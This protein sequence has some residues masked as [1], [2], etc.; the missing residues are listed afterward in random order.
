MKSK[1]RFFFFFF[2]FFL[3]FSPP[4][5]GTCGSEVHAGEISNGLTPA[6]TCSGRGN[7]TAGARRRQTQA[8]GRRE[9]RTAICSRQRRLRGRAL[10]VTGRSRFQALGI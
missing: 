8:G 4:P 2:L 5:L 10:P 6:H 1:A 9:L 7:G 3:P